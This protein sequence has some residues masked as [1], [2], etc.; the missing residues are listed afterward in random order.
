V[1]IAAEAKKETAGTTRR[2]LVNNQILVGLNN[3][4][5]VKTTEH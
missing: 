5:R 2:F 3:S 4:A 1:P